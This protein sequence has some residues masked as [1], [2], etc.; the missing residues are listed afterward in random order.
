MNDDNVNSDLANFIG[1]NKD[2]FFMANSPFSLNQGASVVPT[3]NNV[4]K[5]QTLVELTKSL[6]DTPEAAKA[7]P[8]GNFYVE[9]AVAKATLGYTA[10]KVELDATVSGDVDETSENILSI[11]NLE[12][13]LSNMEKSSYIVRNLGDYATYFPYA[14]AQAPSADQYRFV[15][16]TKLGTTHTPDYTA[17]LYRIYWCKDPAYN[18]DKSAEEGVNYDVDGNVVSFTPNFTWQKTGNDNPQYCHENTFDTPHQ[19]H[20]NTTRAIL[21][22]E[23][24]GGKSFWTLNNRQDILYNDFNN[25]K[26]YPQNYILNSKIIETAVKDALASIEGVTNTFTD[27]NKILTITF[28]DAPDAEGLIKV[29]KIEFND[30][31]STCMIG[32]TRQFAKKPELSVELEKTLRDAANNEFKI[33][34]YSNG[35]NY[36]NIW[37]K[38]FAGEPKDGTD[39]APW[40]I[41]ATNTPDT[42]ASYPG[43]NAENNWLG[44]YGMVRNNWYDIN[45]TKIQKLGTPVP[46]D[47]STDKTPDDVKEEDKWVSF[48][49]NVLSWAKRTQNVEL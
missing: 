32:E 1:N 16:D 27:F 3:D 29:T 30:N 14:N 46:T 23:L 21:K 24:N 37:I 44:R 38:H 10:S 11:S 47:A 34:E 40:N 7:M 18:K 5:V 19:N 36:Y 35:I 42:A 31:Y 22:V 2:H 9:R 48:T 6:Y 49:V 4:A 13:T 39:L 25:V 33:S 26:T 17:N 12:W 41:E 20:I 28:A 15:G 45:V 43:D 8:A